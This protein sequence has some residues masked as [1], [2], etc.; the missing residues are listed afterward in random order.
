MP[1]MDDNA[2]TKK[3]TE[4]LA[5]LCQAV[6][7]NFP[8]KEVPL[9]V[10]ILTGTVVTIIKQKGLTGGEIPSGISA[11]ATYPRNLWNY[12]VAIA[13]TFMS[14]VLL[15]I[16]IFLAGI[17]ALSLIFV[18]TEHWNTVH[19][20]YSIKSEQAP[21]EI[22]IVLFYGILLIC[23]V[24]TRAVAKLAL[25]S[26]L[27]HHHHVTASALTS[28]AAEHLLEL[29]IGMAF[30]V[31]SEKILATHLMGHTW[32]TIESACFRAI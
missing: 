9:V 24:V 21:Y 28:W 15:G 27:S 14:R 23:W 30:Y 8:E 1:D 19:K 11:F 32:L 6:S 25:F 2:V 5:Q 12:L 22:C 18:L 29:V 3:T 20:E 26:T 16:H 7:Q 31:G 13:M 17:Q 4:S 10:E